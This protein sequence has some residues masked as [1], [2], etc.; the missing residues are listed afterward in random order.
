MRGPGKGG[1]PKVLL[2]SLALLACQDAE[3][4][5]RSCDGG[6]A[7]ACND[8]GVLYA[9]GEGVPQN[10]ARAAALYQQG[11]DGGEARGCSNLGVLYENGAGV[12]QNSARAVSLYQQGAATSTEPIVRNACSNVI[13]RAGLTGVGDLFI[14]AS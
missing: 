1:L 13:P 7:A 11:C 12:P 6:N 10:S 8:L 4:V 14:A 3:R 2:V 9:D 5:R